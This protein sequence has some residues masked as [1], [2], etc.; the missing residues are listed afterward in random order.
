MAI[1]ALS[2]LELGNPLISN[3]GRLISREDS[4]RAVKDD[5]DTVRL[6]GT[7]EGWRRFREA[8]DPGRPFVGVMKDQAAITIKVESIGNGA[9]ITILLAAREWSGSTALRNSLKSR[10]TFT[11]V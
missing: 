11:E 3:V 6:N 9:M 5:P 2:V 7:V 1:V 10:G 4:L 8:S